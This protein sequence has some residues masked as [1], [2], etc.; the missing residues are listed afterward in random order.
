MKRL[1]LILAL[2]GS[3]CASAPPLASPV[4]TAD[5]RNTQVIQG[6]DQLRDIAINANAQNPPLLSTATTRK[7]VQAHEA[8]LKTIHAMA[9]GWQATVLAG[10]W[11]PLAPEQTSVVQALPSSQETLSMMPS[12]SSSTALQISLAPGCVAELPSSQSVE[13]VT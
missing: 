9:S 4:A 3:A 12:Q 11:Q 10:C 6:L 7:V 1:I 2:A 5:F 8:A 13:S